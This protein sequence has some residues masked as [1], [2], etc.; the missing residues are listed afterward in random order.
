MR[1][2]IVVLAV[3]VG[4]VSSGLAAENSYGNVIYA[5]NFYISAKVIKNKLIQQKT[6]LNNSCGPTSLAF[7]LN[8]FYYKKHNKPAPIF[9]SINGSK[10]LI[11][12]IYEHISTA[13]FNDTTSLDELK[14]VARKFF[15][16][17]FP[18]TKRL[19]SNDLFEINR[20]N[21]IETL[22]SDK[23]ALIVLD[24]FYEKSPVYEEGEYYRHIVIVYAYVHRKDEFNRP[25][26]HSKNTHNNDQLYYFDPYY[27]K[28][29][30]IT[31]KEIKNNA[32]DLV[33]LAYL[34][35]GVR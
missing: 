25:A 24:G 33:N 18:G 14:S 27:G 21:L 30:F 6:G 4:L 16:W 20:K 1:K 7:A 26:L 3:L 29:H 17:K 32:L 2:L 34:Q 13:G 5:N 19:D 15:K 8:Y 9:S 28:T 35:L 11:K 22:K 10:Y 12:K 23:L 31:I